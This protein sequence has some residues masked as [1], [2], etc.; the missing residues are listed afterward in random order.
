MKKKAGVLLL[1]CVMMLVM[2]SC[3]KQTEETAVGAGTAAVSDTVQEIN[4]SAPLHEQLMT[5]AQNYIV[6]ARDLAEKGMTLQAEYVYG[7][8]Q[9]EISSLR[10]CLDTILWL[11]GEGDD[12]DAVIG[13]A[14]YRDWDT[15]VGTGLGSPMPFYFEGLLDTIQGKDEEA[16]QLYTIA[17]DNPNYTER[18]FYYLKGMPVDELYALREEVSALENALI[19][20]YSPRT[21]LIEPRTGLENSYA[22]HLGLASL[23]SDGE[24]TEESLQSAINALASD[25]LEPTLYV[26]VALYAVD[27]GDIDAAY[28][29][30]NEGLYVF[31]E[32]NYINYMAAAISYADGKNEQAKQFLDVARNGAD[33]FLMEQ[34]DDLASQIGA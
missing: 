9:A 15:I 29:Y 16:E 2:A 25:P 3:G 17:K 12:L 6:Q 7:M 33:D 27:A 4:E 13:D 11:K 5:E 22:Y 21:K 19:A 14:R 28:D 30:I 26:A 32:D 31:P 20:E 23:Y 8:A 18:D 24:L 10:L 1:V 34:I